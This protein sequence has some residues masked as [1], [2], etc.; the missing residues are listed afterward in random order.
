L[1]QLCTLATA[2]SCSSC[3]TQTLVVPVKVPAVLGVQNVCK[4]HGSTAGR[5]STRYPTRFTSC[6]SSHLLPCRTLS[7]CTPGV[8]VF[9][10]VN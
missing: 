7:S 6:Q 8:F 3:C 5:T 2:V 10:G 4:T 1:T 9:T